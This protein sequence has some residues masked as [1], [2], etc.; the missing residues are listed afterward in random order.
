MITIPSEIYTSIHIWLRN[1]YGKANKCENNSCKKI[2]TKYEW[3]KLKNK[4]HGYD[5]NNYVML[6]VNCHRKYDNQLPLRKI[7][8]NISSIIRKLRLHLALEKDE[9]CDL[10]NVE[11]KKYILYET[12]NEL[13]SIK[14]LRSIKELYDKEK[15]ICYRDDVFR[16]HIEYIDYTNN[17][18]I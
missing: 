4:N 12:G 9:F 14:V 1:V 3:A 16:K 5:R 11:I 8:M 10:I 2:S 13:P 6:C 17:K 15:G 7:E 18:E